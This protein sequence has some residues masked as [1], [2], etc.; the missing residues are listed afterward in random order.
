MSFESSACSAR[1][2]LRAFELEASHVRDVEHPAVLPHGPVLGDDA[3]VLDGHL[4]AGERHHARAER[5]V[6]FVERRAKQGLHARPMLMKAQETG[7][8]LGGAA[9][10]ATASHWLT[11]RARSKYLRR[12]FLNGLYCQVRRRARRTGPRARRQGRRTRL[13]PWSACP[14]RLLPR[15]DAPRADGAGSAPAR[16]PSRSRSRAPRP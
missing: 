3:L 2:H 12:R 4:P 15:P 13:H 1:R 16:T 6:A 9:D 11:G 10:R 8:P 7:Q 14:L 5:D